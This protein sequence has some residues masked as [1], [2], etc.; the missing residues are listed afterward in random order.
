MIALETPKFVWFIMRGS[1]FVALVLFSLTVALGVVGVR[2]WQSVRWPRLVTAGLHR[3][4][5]LVAL[6]FLVLHV[7]TAGLDGWVGLGW[8][9]AIVPFQSHYRPL[10]IGL[11]VIAGDLLLAVMMTSLLRRHLH[12]RVWHAVHL[13]VWLMWP[14]AIAHAL[15][16]GSDASS[17]WGLGLCVSCIALVTGAALW[18][19]Q[20]ARRTRPD[21]V[22]APARRLPLV[23]SP[24]AQQAQSTSSMATTGRPT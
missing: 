16:S 20:L 12:Y 24:T 5:A 15:G 7:V 17:T 6:C 11:G 10:W 22:V 13:S 1:G 8:L 23:A 14:L 21:T 19:L 4:L 18:R 2:R 9:G 3:N